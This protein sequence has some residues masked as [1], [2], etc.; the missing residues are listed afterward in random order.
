MTDQ[1]V[2]YVC[3]DFSHLVSSEL[4]LLEKGYDVTTVLGTDGVMAHSNYADC[5]WVILGDGAVEDRE[6]VE[7]WLKVNYPSIPVIASR[8]VTL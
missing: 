4:A 1:K 8:D 2:V 7:R 5:S 6:F 3:F